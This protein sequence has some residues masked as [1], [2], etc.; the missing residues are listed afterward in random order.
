MKTLYDAYNHLHKIITLHER[1]YFF[2]NNFFYLSFG[3]MTRVMYIQ[4]EKETILYY[5]YCK[6]RRA[7]PRR[8]DKHVCICFIY[9]LYIHRV[10]MSAGFSCVDDWCDAPSLFI[11][12][13]S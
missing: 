9:I 5:V 6:H 7:K 10:H 1:A 2:L 11:V 4:Q 13:V 12:P 3:S 8:V